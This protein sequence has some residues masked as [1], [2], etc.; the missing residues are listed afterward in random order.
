M[1]FENLKL[2][3]IRNVCRYTPD[4]LRFSSKN[5]REHIVGIQISGEA[6]HY[7]SD[8]ELF[9]KAS[10]VYFLNQ[11]EDYDVKVCEKGTAFSIHFTTYEPIETAGFCMQIQNP[12]KIINILKIAE[13]EFLKGSSLALSAAFY[14]LCS[15]I[16]EIHAQKLI[17]RDRRITQAEEYMKEH[18]RE[19]DC[20][21]KAV[22]CSRLSARRFNDLFKDCFCE[23]PG[24]YLLNLKISYAKQALRNEIISLTQISSLC[25]FND[26][27]YFSKAFKQSAGMS[28]SDYRKKSLAGEIID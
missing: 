17:L 28:P 23:T 3:E 6:M 19:E 9:F 25:G 7:F 26:S 13:S 10:S 14:R 2:K 8:K 20:L 1:R 11:S 22:S 27:S 21:A 16:N 24:K 15:E 12:G 5:K 18:F 4:K